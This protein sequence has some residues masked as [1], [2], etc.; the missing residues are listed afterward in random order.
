MGGCW[1]QLKM[2][3]KLLKDSSIVWYALI[4]YE[5]LYKNIIRSSCWLLWK[6]QQFG[7]ALVHSRWECWKFRG[8]IASSNN[9][10]L[11]RVCWEAK[12]VQQDMLEL[13]CWQIIANLW[14]RCCP[15]RITRTSFPPIFIIGCPLINF[16]WW[17]RIGW[18]WEQVPLLSKRHPPILPLLSPT[19]PKFYLMP[20]Y[21]PIASHRRYH[22][23]SH[24][25][26]CARTVRA[27]RDDRF[28]RIGGTG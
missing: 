24:P 12:E 27:M 15:Y 3:E 4:C 8:L 7:W 13:C 5:N 20:F 17:R 18:N 2:I 14:L 22:G 25:T 19:V 9:C 23:K 26:I 21:S 1:L 16:S 28:I 6:M 11:L 10:L